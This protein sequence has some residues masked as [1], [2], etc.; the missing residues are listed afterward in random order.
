[1]K[2]LQV[3]D[4]HGSSR[5]AVMIGSKAK[6]VGAD[7]VLVVGDITNFGSVEG[8]EKILS[9][10]VELAHVPILFVPGNCDP[11]QLLSYSPRSQNLVNIHAKKI[12]ISG[13]TFVGV[14]GSKTTPHRGTWI[15]FSE[16]ELGEILAGLVG[17]DGLIDW[18]FVSHNPPIGVEVSMAG[19]GVDLGST[20][21]RRF[22]ESYKPIVV[23]CGHVHEARGISYLGETPVVNAGPAKEGYCTLIELH[24][25]HAH[26]YLDTL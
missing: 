17:G 6:D 20:S 14:G 26:V 19:S 5:S 10:I 9:T 12:Q 7:I 8:A 2:I 11:P 16:E 18:V 13:Y 22:I 25:R 4:I 15:E 24:E 3:S 1:M 21:I 23:C